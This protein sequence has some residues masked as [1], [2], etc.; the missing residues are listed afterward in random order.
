MVDIT[1]LAR[2]F[3]KTQQS[4]SDLRKS[5]IDAFEAAF[6]DYLMNHEHLVFVFPDLELRKTELMLRVRSH[7][8]N[9]TPTS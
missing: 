1:E 7:A 2:L 5:D 6:D 3:I 9:L 4:F 8:H